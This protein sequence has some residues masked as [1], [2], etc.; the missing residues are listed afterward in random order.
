MALWQDKLGNL[1]RE[2]EWVRGELEEE[3]AAAARKGKD[4]AGRAREADTAVARLKSLH[5]EEAKRL[6]KEKHQ[7]AERVQVRFLQVFT[8]VEMESRWQ[9]A[10]PHMIRSITL[11]TGCP[12][13]S[14]PPAFVCNS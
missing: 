10:A 14:A 8:S 5:K 2:L 11:E 4:A 9:F 13:C 7:L 3:R 1:E 12:A 6:G